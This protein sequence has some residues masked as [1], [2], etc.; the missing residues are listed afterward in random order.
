M[1][2]PQ[3]THTIVILTHT[4]T[5]THTNT[6]TQHSLQNSPQTPLTHTHLHSKYLNYWERTSTAQA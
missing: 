1:E 4:H 2:I 5:H 3:D 6:N